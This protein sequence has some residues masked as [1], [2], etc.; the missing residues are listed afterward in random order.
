MRVKNV[1]AAVLLICTALA[2]CNNSSK[3]NQSAAPVQASV[4]KTNL[5]IGTDRM[6]ATGYIIGEALAAV[7][8]KYA[9]ASTFATM[10]TNG[11]SENMHLL[12]VNEI[13]FGNGTSRDWYATITGDTPF[14]APVVIDQLFGVAWYNMPLFVIKNS[15]IKTYADLQGKRIFAGSAGSGVF[16]I[17]T[18]LFTTLGIFDKVTWVDTSWADAYE[19]IRNGTIDAAPL[20]TL[21]NK[22]SASVSQLEELLEYRVLQ[23]SD[24]SGVITTMQKIN[25]GYLENTLTPDKFKYVTEDVTFPTTSSVFGCLP[26]LSEDAVYDIVKT[27][28]DHLDEVKEMAPDLEDLTPKLAVSLIVRDVPV[29]PG[30]AKYFKEIGA[31]SNDLTIRGR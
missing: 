29:H 16:N 25:G 26:S 22:P 11:G 12:S 7:V 15:P 9:V 10:S 5:V 8:N 20:L 6:G 17:Y 13:A 3:T 19:A 21:N 28:F 14:T 4:Q 2:G 31:W 27:I 30:A 24:P 1:L 18:D 23:L